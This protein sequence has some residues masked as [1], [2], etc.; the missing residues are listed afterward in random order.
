MQIRKANLAKYRSIWDSKGARDADRSLDERVALRCDA[1][2]SAP[3]ESV[4]LSDFPTSHGVFILACSFFSAP[5]RASPATTYYILLL[6]KF[7]K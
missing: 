2:V 1:G 7:L 6:K 4:A 5:Q 3:K